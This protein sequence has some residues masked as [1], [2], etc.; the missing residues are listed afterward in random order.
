MIQYLM[1]SKLLARGSTTRDQP[2][3]SSRGDPLREGGGAPGG[4]A[5]TKVGAEEQHPV[6]HRTS[7]VT[8]YVLH[9]RATRYMLHVTCSL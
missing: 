4:E 6:T 3:V 1:M 9:V 5:L 7:H 2:L 8:R